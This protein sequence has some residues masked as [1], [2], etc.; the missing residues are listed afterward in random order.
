MAEENT[1]IQEHSGES[2]YQTSEER[3]RVYQAG[4]VKAQ[5]LLD[6]IMGSSIV[7]DGKLV[8]RSEAKYQE[9]NKKRDNRGIKLDYV[10]EFFK[11]LYISI[12]NAL[13]PIDKRDQNEIEKLQADSNA[14]ADV[15]KK[16]TDFI[17]DKNNGLDKEIYKMKIS[18]IKNLL[19]F[20]IVNKDIAEANQM[21][22]VVNADLE[23]ILSSNDLSN[24][25]KINGLA[26]EN[27]LYEAAL[28]KY[29]DD[30]RTLDVQFEDADIRIEFYLAEKDN[31]KKLRNYVAEEKTKVDRA[32]SQA[33][34]QDRT[35]NF[36]MILQ[37]LPK[38]Q[39]TL[40]RVKEMIENKRDID[41]Q[42]LD[43]VHNVTK[44]GLNFDLE[45][46]Q[47]E[48]PLKDYEKVQEDREDKIKQ[49][50]EEI[51]KKPF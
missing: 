10:P 48:S 1:I 2:K 20:D 3:R 17:Y 27:S 46:E 44:I 40:N 19:A 38:T 4:N 24:I 37:N 6:E 15:V 36:Q 11:P 5:K 16:I 49:R 14:F 12:Y 33:R 23:N 9:L 18:R 25:E 51:R 29:D 22:K 26:E 34:L 41:Y 30:K 47:R 45:K 43:Y 31:I 32:I 35:S 13:N 8:E 28:L 21:M 50:R 7:V 39:D 42:K